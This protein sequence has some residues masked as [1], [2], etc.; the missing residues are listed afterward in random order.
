MFMSV[1]KLNKLRANERKRILLHVIKSIQSSQGVGEEF[2]LSV[3]PVNVEKLMSRG[4]IFL[5]RNRDNSFLN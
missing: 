4:S 3:F 1:C 5:I 2:P